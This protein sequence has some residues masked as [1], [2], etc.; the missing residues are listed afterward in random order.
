MNVTV[1]ESL[2]ETLRRRFFP[3][4]D[5]IDPNYKYFGLDK[6]GTH[7]KSAITPT[8]HRNQWTGRSVEAEHLE[9]LEKRKAERKKEVDDYLRN[10]DSSAC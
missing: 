5:D 7:P 3:T 4:I 2:M 8:D 6:V 10:Y 1:D 9:E